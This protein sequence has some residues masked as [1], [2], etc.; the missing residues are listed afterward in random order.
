MCNETVHITQATGKE[1][2]FVRS[3]EDLDFDNNILERK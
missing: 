2:F 1:I 3:K